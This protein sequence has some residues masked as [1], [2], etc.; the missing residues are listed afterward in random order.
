MFISTVRNPKTTPARTRVAA[1]TSKVTTKSNAVRSAC[2]DATTRL[3]SK[4]DTIGEGERYAATIR[5][6]M[7]FSYMV[8]VRVICIGLFPYEQDIL[9]PI[10]S[11]LAYS[12]V[13]C[14]APT[15]GVQVLAQGMAM[16]AARAK[17]K[18]AFKRAS[19]DVPANMTE[20]AFLKEFTMMLRCSCVCAAAGVFF[21][22]AVPIPVNTT[23]KRVR[24]ASHFAE[25][26]A[27]LL[28]IHN[29]F[30]YR[31]LVLSMGASASATVKRCFSSFPGTSS[32]TN[33][34]TCI[35]P[36]AVSYMKLNT[37]RGESPIPNAVTA[38]ETKLAEIVGVTMVANEVRNYDWVVYSETT[39]VRLMGTDALAA[40]AR[41]LADHTV[42]ELASTTINAMSG[43]FA[44]MQT[45]G[46]SGG[47]P[48]AD[49]NTNEEA[50]EDASA[51]PNVGAGG[52]AIMNTG[53]GAQ[54]GLSRGTTGGAFHSKIEVSKKSLIGQ[55]MDPMNRNK[56]QQVLVIE[57]MVKS[58]ADLVEMYKNREV[59]IRAI[60][61]EI[62]NMRSWS[63]T[64]E[65][66]NTFISSYRETMNGAMEDL[67]TAA[68]V[69][70]AM[71]AVIDG[72]RGVIEA[73]IQPA[74]PIMRRADGTSI[75]DSLF[76][77]A[78]DHGDT[79]LQPNVSS[80]TSAMPMMSDQTSS[81]A[82][83]PAQTPM[84]GLMEMRVK[85]SELVP[86]IMEANVD[87]DVSAIMMENVSDCRDQTGQTDTDVAT[88]LIEAMAIYAVAKR[89]TMPSAEAIAAV[90]SML[91][92]PTKEVAIE[93]ADMLANVIGSA[94]SVVDLFDSM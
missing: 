18:Y 32:M 75:R 27:S 77:F 69:I 15:P 39:M 17:Q 31:P 82:F 85:A 68:A 12:P 84:D 72:D 47:I 91:N 48:S 93:T 45:T 5:S 8:P 73:E 24:A 56:S 33:H 40:L 88:L 86:E 50:E 92:P 9:P 89:G 81:G 26:L 60:E 87:A 38:M 64:D 3:I 90:I 80:E 7:L 42:D 22:N 21:T 57:H 78:K 51:M 94:S 25:W 1:D 79:P 76:V 71:P 53:M 63:N 11:A 74:A 52:M 28:V 54:M 70:A 41:A 37:E 14:L 66:I 23:A 2:L 30:G 49:A 59:K 83:T 34:I 6:L 4:L 20:E 62:A 16:S 43:L 13:S 58:V 61:D 35:N 29:R 55:M 67:K 46:P 44:Y 36:A 10:A 19:G 65:D